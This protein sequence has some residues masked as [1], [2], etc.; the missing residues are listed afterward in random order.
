[1]HRDMRRDDRALDHKAALA[2]LHGGEYGVL[3]TADADNQPYGIPVS[4]AVIDNAIYIHSALQGHKLDNI[5]ANARVSFCVV[6]KT[7]LLPKKFST[8]YESVIVFGVASMVADESKREPLVALVEKYSPE[9]IES[10]H[11]YID[12]LINET[13][14]IKVTIE[15]ITG[16]ARK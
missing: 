9:Y 12:K 6:G 11:K 2:L 3:S 10:G 15:S 13:A 14:V 7:E 4:Y 8:K 5:A 16:K 1:M